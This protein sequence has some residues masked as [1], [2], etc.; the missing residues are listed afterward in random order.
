MREGFGIAT[1][2][3]MACGVP[4]VATN[5]PGSRDILENSCAGELV[6][7]NNIEKIVEIIALLIS[8]RER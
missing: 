3:A 1:A 6:P 8:D 4:V 5:V 7:P 2:E